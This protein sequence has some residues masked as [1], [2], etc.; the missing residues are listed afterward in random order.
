[1]DLKYNRILLKLSGEALAGDQKFGL[2]YDI[3]NPICEAIRDAAALGA[4]IAVV[5][6]GGLL[7]RAQLWFDGSYPRRPY[8]YV[9]NRDECTGCR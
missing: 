9:G 7:E 8:R 1:M 6:G 5:V 3:I 4:Q 2:N